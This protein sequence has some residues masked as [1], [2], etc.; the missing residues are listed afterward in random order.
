MWTITC[1]YRTGSHCYCLVVA[2][3][4]SSGYCGFYTYL[5]TFH[6]LFAPLVLIL[7][8]IYI[9]LKFSGKAKAKRHK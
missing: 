4:Q 1:F 9:S 2:P 7:L 6:D 3:G 5:F 8:S